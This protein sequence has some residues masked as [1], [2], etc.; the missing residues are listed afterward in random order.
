MGIG[1]RYADHS[2]ARVPSAEIPRSSFDRSHSHKTTFD[3][4]YLVPFY[5]DLAYPGDTFHL[6]AT[7]F[8]RLSATALA[9]P[10]M[11]NLYVD[12]FFFAVPIRLIW[13]NFQKFMG[14][15]DNPADSTSYSIPQCTSPGGGAGVATGDVGDY[16]GLPTKT[17]AAITF[18]NL[19]HR[20]YNLCWNKWFRDENLQNSVTVDTGDGPDTYSNY[21]SLLR[22]G[23]RHD[24]FT[25]CLPWPQ[26]AT[27]VSIPLGTSATVK[28]SATNLVTGAQEALS[29]LRTDGNNPT[30]GKG[31]MVG[32]PSGA[33]FYPYQSTANDAGSADNPLYPANLYADL[34]TATAATINSLRLAFQ[35]QKLYERD[36]RGG[37]RYTEII[38]AHFGV[39]SPDARLQRPEYL[40]G[41][42]MP[43]NVHPVAGTNQLGTTTTAPGKL[44]AFGTASGSG[45]GFSKSFVEH[46]ILLGLVNVRADLS[47]QQGMNRMFSYRTRTDM[48]WPALANI[49]EQSVLNQEIYADG[50]ANDALVFGYQERYGEMRYKPSLVT[51]KFRSNAT[52]TLESWHLAQN[53]GAL[54]TLGSTFI[55]DNPPVSRI[56]AVT[57]EP[58]IIMDSFIKLICARPMPMFG[59]PGN[60][61][62]F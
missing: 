53:F 57:T 51:G 61:D 40:G 19:W 48:Y 49:G 38:K 23:K 28:T 30:A 52:G 31:L 4:G 59:V 62:R 33:R 47:Y 55:Q 2:F 9:N 56:V 27:A 36:A 58:Q 60:I 17:A 22:R 37:T 45:H 54:P 5:A 39:V 46:C 50:S 18:N 3:T 10:P 35:L 7:I 11:D 16:L 26:K 24:Y 42:S 43:I 44:S 1:N 13:S 14:E 8:A 32:T 15:Q 41:G 12:T 20:S 29:L 34:S 6:D 25:S 21:S